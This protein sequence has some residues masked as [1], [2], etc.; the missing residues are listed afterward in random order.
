MIEICVRSPLSWTFMWVFKPKPQLH[1]QQSPLGYAFKRFVKS[2]RF[3]SKSMKGTPANLSQCFG[4][5]VSATSSWDLGYLGIPWATLAQVRTIFQ[6]C[7]RAAAGEELSHWWVKSW[8]RELR[9]HCHSEMPNC[10]GLFRT[11]CLAPGGPT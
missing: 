11:M 4:C 8:S 10:L 1:P 2:W 5:S 6:Y 9:W 7:S 3:D